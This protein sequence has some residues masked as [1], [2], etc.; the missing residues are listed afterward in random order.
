MSRPRATGAWSRRGTP[1]GLRM[2]AVIAVASIFVAACGPKTRA[3]EENSRPPSS[4]RVPGNATFIPK[5]GDFATIEIFEI[6]PNQ[7]GAAA[8]EFVSGVLPVIRDR[9]GLRDAWLMR[10]E[11]NSRLVLTSVWNDAVAF[12]QWQISEQRLA[13]Y[14]K[15]GVFL[16]AQPVAQPVALIGIIAPPRP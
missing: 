12:Q 14:Q 7:V 2:A 13:A 8:T 5:I 10:D 11:T 4:P 9:G 1:G 6:L 16:A 3:L 15:L